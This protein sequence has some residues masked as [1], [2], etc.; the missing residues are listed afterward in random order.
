MLPLA[1]LA[2]GSTLPLLEILV[3][4]T[5]FLMH[6]HYVLLPCGVGIVALSI[7]L[8]LLLQPSSFVSSFTFLS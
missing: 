6:L 2:A 4:L 1:D 3:L 7:V 5:A 8:R